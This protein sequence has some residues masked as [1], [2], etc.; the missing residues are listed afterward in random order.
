MQPRDHM[1]LCHARA[2]GAGGRQCQNYVM[3]GQQV[4]RMHGGKSPQALAKA[5]DR[6]RALIHPAISALAE[7]I[8]Q[9]DL[10]A[11][12]YTLDWGGFKAAVTAQVDQQITIRVIDEAQPIILERIHELGN[13]DTRA[14]R[15]NGLSR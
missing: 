7:L 1:Q 10:G 4:C 11:V 9:R 14:P 12:R 15:G 8:E 13:G 5:E 3:H 6:M 2:Q